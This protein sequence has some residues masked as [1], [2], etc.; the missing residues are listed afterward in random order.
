MGRNP[1]RA[2][3]AHSRKSKPARST[4]ASSKARVLDSEKKNPVSTAKSKRTEKKSS[5]K[6]T[7]RS[8][9]TKDTKSE[10]ASLE[11]RPT[12]SYLAAPEDQCAQCHS[13]LVSP[14][15]TLFVENEVGRNFCSE[16]CILDFFHPEVE[17]AERRHHAW[18]KPT[19]FSESQT[20]AWEHLKLDLL[21]QP[22]EVWRY[23]NEKL[24]PRYFLIRAV[25]TPEGRAAWAVGNCLLLNGEPSFLFYWFVTKDSSLVDKYR[26]GESRSNQLRDSQDESSSGESPV[27]RLAESWTREDSIRVSILG[28]RKT[29]DIPDDEFEQYQDCV[30][31]TLKDPNEVWSRQDE[32]QKSQKVFAFIRK[33][34]KTSQRE[35]TAVYW[36]VVLAKETEDPDQLEIV[37]L[38]PSRDSSYVDH[39]RIG[40]QEVG[41]DTEAQSQPKRSA[42]H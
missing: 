40:V 1:I 28:T 42:V 38:F 33:F 31:S 25:Q 29:T 16:T 12:D 20:M 23:L 14:E 6:S 21:R 37:D 7:R 39:F 9:K 24:E 35:T 22:N 17:A 19:D 10:R 2:K 5:P 18:R 27:D 15:A 4:R 3:N 8:S 36:Y 13:K 41:A 32:D 11:L 34:Q 30:D 26:M